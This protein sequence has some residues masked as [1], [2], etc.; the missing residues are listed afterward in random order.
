MNERRFAPIALADGPIVT[1]RI[2]PSRHVRDM[3]DLTVRLLT[4]DRWAE[5]PRRRPPRP[6]VRR[7]TACLKRSASR[8]ATRRSGTQR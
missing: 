7:S 1:S 5:M 3:R 6:V 2:R 8:R 4:T